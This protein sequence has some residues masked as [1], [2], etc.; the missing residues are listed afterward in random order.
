MDDLHAY[1]WK[2]G[3]LAGETILTLKNGKIILDY[4]F[5]F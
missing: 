1:A 3:S 2:A 4:T 5:I